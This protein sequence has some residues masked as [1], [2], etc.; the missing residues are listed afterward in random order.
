MALTTGLNSILTMQHR[1][2]IDLGAG[3]SRNG[4]SLAQAIA[5]ALASGDIE[6]GTLYANESGG[7]AKAGA[8]LIFSTSSGSVGAVIN[9][10]TVTGS[11]AGTDT[12][13]A[14]AAAAAINASS[15]ALVAGLVRASE[16]F[17]TLTLSSTAAGSTVAIR[18]GGSTFTFTAVAGTATDLGQFD[19]SG[20]DT[21]DA[22]ALAAA[23]NAFPVLNQT[24]RAESVAGVCYVYAMDRSI[25][26]KAVTCNGVTLTAAFA[27]G[28]RVHV[29]AIVP[30]AVGNCLT[31]AATG[32]GVTVA[33]A[34]SRLVGGLGGRTG[35]LK[36][37]NFGG[38]Q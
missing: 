9:G 23:I 30:G 4:K 25:T 21:A 36:R 11:G 8:S 29:E 31:F 32:T 37:A 22:A 26:D 6:A 20:N 34:N 35:T 16:Y 19:Q 17:A 13:D 12:Q 28:T 2:R 7:G 10:V 3:N 33:N 14:A 27:A 1:R 38:A 5:A 18:V 15:D 24:C